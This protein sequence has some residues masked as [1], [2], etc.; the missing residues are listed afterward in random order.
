[1]VLAAGFANQEAPGARQDVVNHNRG[2]MA[3]VHA[4]EGLPA[5]AARRVRPQGARA[6]I[7]ERSDRGDREAW[8]W[9]QETR[10]LY[11]GAT[12]RPG[13]ERGLGITLRRPRDGAERCAILR[14]PM[15][16]R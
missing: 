1:V 7:W 15:A 4:I 2:M 5:R 8:R 10:A 6:G 12:V 9:R 13:V 16:I 3:A 11:I 14:L